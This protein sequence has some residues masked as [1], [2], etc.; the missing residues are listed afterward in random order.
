M[1][2]RVILPVLNNPAKANDVVYGKQ[3]V[4]AEAKPVTGRLNTSQVYVEWDGG[5]KWL[6]LE[7]EISNGVA[8]LVFSDTSVFGDAVPEHV[9]SGVTFSSSSGVGISGTR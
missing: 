1:G 6:P 9:S 3:I 5:S 7:I 2:N 4:N 8:R